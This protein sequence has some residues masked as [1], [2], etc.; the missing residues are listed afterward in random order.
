MKTVIVNG[1]KINVSVADERVLQAI[2]S[3]VCP[4]SDFTIRRG[5]WISFDLTRDHNHRKDL[6]ILSC[7]SHHNDVPNYVKSE[8]EERP[9]VGEWVYPNKRRVNAI[10][11]QLNA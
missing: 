5:R 9:R 8:M 4:A 2:Q 7:R 10:L 1:K 3:G 6:G 11:K